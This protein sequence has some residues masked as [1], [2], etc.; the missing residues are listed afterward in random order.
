VWAGRP[1][2]ADPISGIIQRPEAMDDADP[3]KR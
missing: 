2:I 3:P 1:L